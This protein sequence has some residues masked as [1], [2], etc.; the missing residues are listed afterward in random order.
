MRDWLVEHGINPD[1]IIMENHS[2]ST[3]ENLEYSLKLI[4]E[5]GGSADNIAIVS[6]PYHLY[7]AKT[8][9]RSI[10]IEPAGVACVYGYPIFTLGMF[11]REAFGVTHL[12]VFGD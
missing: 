1:R 3:M 6:S 8:M 12:W 4:I 11:I 9:A 5:D 7:R 10:G 2:T